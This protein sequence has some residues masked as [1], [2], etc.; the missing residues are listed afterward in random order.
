MLHLHCLT[1]SLNYQTLSSKCRLQRPNVP[2]LKIPE[3]GATQARCS[4]PSSPTVTANIGTHAQIHQCV[5][6]FR[7]KRYTTHIRE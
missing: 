7:L 6:S 3:K 2:S 1:N 5:L 4:A